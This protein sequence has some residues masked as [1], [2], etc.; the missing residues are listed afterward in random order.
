MVLDKIKNNKK[1]DTHFLFFSGKGGVGKT[2]VAAA[3]ALWY[4]KKGKRTLVIS[5]DPAHSLAD[6][7]DTKI[8]GEVKK[9]GKNLYGVEIDPELSMKEYKDMIS[10]Q[11]DKISA[12]KGLGLEDTFD[13]AGMT[14]GIDEVAS[15]DRFLRY[16]NS[17]EYDIIVFDTAPTGHT[18]RLLSLPDVLDSWLGKIIKLRMRFSGIAGAVKRFMGSG[19]DEKDNTLEKLEEMKQRIEHAKRLLTD[20]S[21]TSYNIV[22][23]PEAM[24]ILESERS[25]CFLDNVCIPIHSIVINQII[26][27]NPSCSFCT[28]KRK[29]QLSRI[30]DIR[31]RFSKYRILELNLFKEEVRGKGML[32]RVSKQLYG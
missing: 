9:L 27:E 25:V 14:P 26:P 1:R 5:T 30:E 21:K 18:L 22:M 12:L 28:G 19:D 11:L 6:S 17:N 16:M 7:F 20:P 3:T 13:M 29:L 8:G 31:K 23:I 32:E 10:P 4:A 15:F 24:S 2:S